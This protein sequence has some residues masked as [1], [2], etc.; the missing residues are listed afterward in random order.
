M[1]K[2][3][4]IAQV[5]VSK[6]E[7]VLVAAKGYLQKE[8]LLDEEKKIVNWRKAAKLPLITLNKGHALR[9]CVEVLYQN[10]GLKPNIFM[11]SHSN[12]LSYR[13]A[14]QGMGIAVVPEITLELM[15]GSMEAEAF[16]LSKIPVTW[17]V[18]ALYREDCYIGEVEQELLEITCDVLE[19]HRK[20][21]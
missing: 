6:E 1:G 19:A 18:Q 15:Q 10:A 12:M 4:D 20:R 5:E 8:H 11:E 9:S 3:K 7:L 2:A 14:A 16:H 21:L 13:L 17:E